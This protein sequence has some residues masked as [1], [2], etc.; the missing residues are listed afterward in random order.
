[1]KSGVLSNFYFQSYLLNLVLIFF[2]FI[3]WGKKYYVGRST[4][5]EEVLSGKKYFI[6]WGKKL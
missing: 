2:I 1:M 6:S 3:S 5:G 4:M